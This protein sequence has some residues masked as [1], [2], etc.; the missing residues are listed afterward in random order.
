MEAAHI[1]YASQLTR[2]TMVQV[3]LVV[4]GPE[5]RTRTEID[6]ENISHAVTPQPACA[7]SAEPEVES[8]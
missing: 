2:A 6:I 5:F 1:T 7:W 8:M 3:E 4:E